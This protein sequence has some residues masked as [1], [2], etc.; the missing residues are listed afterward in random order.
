MC[1]RVSYTKFFFCML[2]SWRKGVGS[3]VGSISKRYGSADSDPH[4]NV[5]D[6]QHCIGTVFIMPLSYLLLV[7]L[8]LAGI[9]LFIAFGKELR[10]LEWFAN[11]KF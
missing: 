9:Y 7:H 1:L 4:Q 2:K 11:Y 5:R 6:P 3:G 8:K 10:E